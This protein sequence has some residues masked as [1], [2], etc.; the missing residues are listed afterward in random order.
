MPLTT[1]RSTS[2]CSTL[3][4]IRREYEP[5][6]LTS[7]KANTP[8]HHQLPPPQCNRS[9][10]LDD[11]VLGLGRRAPRYLQHHLLLQPG[12]PNPT[13]NSLFPVS[14]HLDPSLLLREK[15][16]SGSQFECYCTYCVLHGWYR[17]RF[18]FR[19][20]RGCN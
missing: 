2:I 4:K 9:P 14:T 16:V 19:I 13:S 7:L 11:D 8:N 5:S 17:D 12:P 3:N 18:D 1:T 20:E 15:V 6:R 10:A